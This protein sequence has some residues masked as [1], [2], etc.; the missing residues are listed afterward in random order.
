MPV[1][2]KERLGFEMDHP[3]TTDPHVLAEQGMW[4]QRVLPE[5]YPDL[6]LAALIMLRAI[7]YLI[8]RDILNGQYL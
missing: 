6:P 7:R 1:W 8:R 4:M 5:H 2:W 3:L